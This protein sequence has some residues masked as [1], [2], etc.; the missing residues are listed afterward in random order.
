[1][2]NGNEEPSA[3]ALQRNGSLDLLMR[4]PLVAARIELLDINERLTGRE[5]L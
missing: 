2:P 3:E 4:V 5:I 1:M